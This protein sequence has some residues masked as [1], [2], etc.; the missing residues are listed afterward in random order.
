[1]PDLDR[2]VAG[3]RCRD[4]LN[5]LADFVDGELGSASLARVKAHLSGCD[6]CEKFGGEYGALVADLRA[7]LRAPSD[8]AVRTRLTEHM[9]GFWREVD[10]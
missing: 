7:G 8:P 10:G 4:V 9:V 6:T 5:L 3:L 2:L 1:M